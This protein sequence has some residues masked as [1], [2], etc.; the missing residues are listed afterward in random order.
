MILKIKFGLVV[1]DISFAT[2]IA[3]KVGLDSLWVLDH[4]LSISHRM[5]LEFPQITT[6]ALANLPIVLD[7]TRCMVGTSVICPLFRFHP[8]LIGQYFAQLDRIYPNRLILGL[9]AG[10]ACVDGPF[11]D[12][13][14][15]YK[16]RVGRLTEAVEIIKK[17]WTSQGFFDYDGRYYKL[18]NA[19]LYLK[20]VSRIPI[21]ISARGPR[22]AKLAGKFGDGIIIIGTMPDKTGDVILPSFKEGAKEAGKDPTTLIKAQFVF[23]GLATDPYKI[24]SFLKPALA[25]HLYPKAIDEPDPRKIDETIDKMQAEEEILRSNPIREKVDDVIGYFEAYVKRG[26]T[27]LILDDMTILSQKLGIAPKDAEA[28]WDKILG[29]FR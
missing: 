7:K 25:F 10:E 1:Q 23:F 19:F 6:S 4:F 26:I 21:L 11:L 29:Y 5:S 3:D 2:L 13:W 15:S 12:K 17:L 22:T 8:A 24:A 27:M 18:R 28:R 16:E 14:P 20:P 9:G